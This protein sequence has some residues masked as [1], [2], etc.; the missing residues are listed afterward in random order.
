MVGLFAF[1][2]FFTL[3]NFVFLTNEKREIE[4]FF[5]ISSFSSAVL[6]NIVWILFT[7]QASG[8]A[9]G[10]LFAMEGSVIAFAFFN[11][12]HVLA[13]SKFRVQKPVTMFV[14][15]MNLVV[16]ATLLG[17]FFFAPEIFLSLGEGINP[18]AHGL[19]FYLSLIVT[20]ILCSWFYFARKCSIL[21]NHTFE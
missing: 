6:S 15:L 20:G 4:K 11:G 5:L 10:L 16:L 9:S 17:Q 1:V 14:V 7:P 21:K 2:V 18:I 19:S 3:C 12:L 8:G 13:F